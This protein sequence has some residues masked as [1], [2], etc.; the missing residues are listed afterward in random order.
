MFWR[1]TAASFFPEDGKNIPIKTFFIASRWMR[2]F[3]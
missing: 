2:R 3:K 1:V